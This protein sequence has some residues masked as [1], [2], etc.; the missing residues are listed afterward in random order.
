MWFKKALQEIPVLDFYKIALERNRIFIV[1]QQSAFL[2]IDEIDVNA[3]HIYRKDDQ[4]TLVA[5]IRVY[6]LDESTM[7]FGRVLVNKTKRGN[8]LGHELLSHTLTFLENNY[9]GKDVVIEA[10]EYLINFYKNYGFK[11]ISQ[12]YYDC[13]ILHVTMKLSLQ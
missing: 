12:P 10:E 3:V 1:E 2:D 8:G 9:P 4:G 5:Y 7:S 13:N 11:P 6:E